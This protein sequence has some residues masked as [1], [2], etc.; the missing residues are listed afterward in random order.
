MPSEGES[1]QGPPPSAWVCCD[2]CH[3]W[4][5]ISAILADVIES[6]ECRWTCKENMDK[7]FADCSIPQEKS[8]TDINEEL[9]LSEA[10][11]EEDACNTWLNSNKLVQKQPA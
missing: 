3:K 4:R 10:S 2:D 1:R 7:A 8:N 9:E 5:R 6:T 11:C